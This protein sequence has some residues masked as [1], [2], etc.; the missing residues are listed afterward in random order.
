MLVWKTSQKHMIKFIR[1]YKS[2]NICF[3]FIQTLPV[4]TKL[5]PKL[6]ETIHENM[7]ANLD[8]EQIPIMCQFYINFNHKEIAHK[9]VE[10]VLSTMGVGFVGGKRSFKVDVYEQTYCYVCVM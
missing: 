10:S 9:L 3:E 8:F 4:T 2:A 6:M 1:S 5:P 7:K